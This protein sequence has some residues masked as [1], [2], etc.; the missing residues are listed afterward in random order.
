MAAKTRAA[1]HQNSAPTT[2]GSPRAWTST[3]ARGNTMPRLPPLTPGN[4][5]TA[6]TKHQPSSHVTRA[7]KVGRSRAIAAPETMAGT[8]PTTATNAIA[9]MGSKPQRLWATAA[10]YPPS[11]T[12]APCRE[13]RDPA[14]VEG[15][16]EGDNHRDPE[17][18]GGDI[19]KGRLAQDHR[20]RDRGA[21]GHHTDDHASVHSRTSRAKRGGCVAITAMATRTGRTT[22]HSTPSGPQPPM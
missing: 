16:R 18:R 7:A 15:E 3:T 19:E 6:S 11:P 12:K 9:A 20:H 1:A 5:P 4:A 14:G 2:N 17:D 13:R 22:R 10:P 21:D 8:K